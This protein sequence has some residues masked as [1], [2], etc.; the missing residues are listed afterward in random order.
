MGNSIKVM[1][2]KKKMLFELQHEQIVGYEECHN[3]YGFSTIEIL[4]FNFDGKGNALVLEDEEIG[5]LSN[6][7]LLFLMF[8]GWYR[9]KETEV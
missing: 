4:E 8:S 2:E 1:I 3:Y 7:D 6:K 9:L 5:C